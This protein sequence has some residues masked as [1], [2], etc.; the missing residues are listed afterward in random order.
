MQRLRY[1]PLM[2]QDQIALQLYTVR[3]LMA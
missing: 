3:T 1:R 2:R